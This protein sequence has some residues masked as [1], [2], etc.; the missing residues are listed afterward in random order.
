LPLSGHSLEAYQS[1]F[2]PH[3]QEIRG[4]IRNFTDRTP[5]TQISEVVIENSA[6]GG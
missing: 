3:A 6:K 5:V 4:D 2:A 1:S